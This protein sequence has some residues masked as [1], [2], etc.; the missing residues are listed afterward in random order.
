LK[1]E[2]NNT[3]GSK[4]LLWQALHF[5]ACV[6]ACSGIPPGLKTLDFSPVTKS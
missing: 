3:F 1:D 4:K 2:A 6:F 5:R